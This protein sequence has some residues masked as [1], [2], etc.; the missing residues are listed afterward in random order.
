MKTW[1]QIIG[2]C[3]AALL[4]SAAVTQVSL[5]VLDRKEAAASAANICCPPGCVCPCPCPCPKPCQ[6]KCQCAC[7]CQCECQCQCQC[8]PKIKSGP[9]AGCPMGPK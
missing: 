6:C 8:P 1:V 4:T 2:L 5:N 3:L 9:C 7:K